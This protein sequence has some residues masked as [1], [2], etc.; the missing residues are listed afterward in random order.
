MAYV[1]G[2]LALISS[3]NGFGFYRYDTTDIVQDVDA[4]GYFNNSDDTLNLAL[5]D[6]ISIVHWST[7]VR[8]GTIFDVSLVVVSE[9]QDDGVV[10][11]S[12]DI[13]QKG[14]F[15]SA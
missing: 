7:A 10:Q 8:T 2:N 1:S 5:G 6:L 9:L 3:V 11:V 13:Y 4:Q 14:I 15:S 12:S